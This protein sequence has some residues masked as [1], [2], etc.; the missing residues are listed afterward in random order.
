M[1]TLMPMTFV[2]WECLRI[3]I[4]D[5]PKHSH[6]FFFEGNRRT[7]RKTLLPE[8]FRSPILWR[9]LF[10]IFSPFLFS[11][12]ISFFR[13]FPLSYF[14][15]SLLPH[16]TSKIPM[17]QFKTVNISNIILHRHF[18]GFFSF[19]APPFS[20]FDNPVRH[21]LV[22]RI[23]GTAIFCFSFEIPE[24]LLPDGLYIWICFRRQT[25]HVPNIIQMNWN[26]AL[27]RLH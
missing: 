27:T 23:V 13:L 20:L 21:A 12:L 6:S 5:G 18:V 25:F 24:H 9:L 7:R 3:M 10:S 17:P 22:F 19:P 26:F 4:L 15:Y 14:L 16:M 11:P 8:P 2:Q 1:L